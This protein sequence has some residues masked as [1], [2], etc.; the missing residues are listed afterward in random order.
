VTWRIS[1]LGGR[2]YVSEHT[3]FVFILRNRDGPIR[4]ILRIGVTK[5]GV[6]PWISNVRQCRIQN[7]TGKA[8]LF[9]FPSFG[10]LYPYHGHNYHTVRSTG[11]LKIQDEN[12]NAA[13]EILCKST[14]AVENLVGIVS[15]LLK[16][17]FAYFCLNVN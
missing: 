8:K 14:A 15:T 1:T 4:H 2:L 5:S 10:T 11:I 17:H 7:M 9:L 3:I 6:T 13:T 16:R 12:H